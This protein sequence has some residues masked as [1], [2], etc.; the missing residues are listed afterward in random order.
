MYSWEIDKII[1]DFNRFLPSSIYSQIS[2]INKNPQIERVKYDAWSGS[3]SIWTKDGW[4]WNFKVYK[5]KE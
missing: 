2:D 3:F 1:A 4:Y 5:D